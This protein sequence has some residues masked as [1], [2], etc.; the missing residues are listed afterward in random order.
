[1]D[2]NKKY[3]FFS[4]DFDVKS[5]DIHQPFN[6]TSPSMKCSHILF[7]VS[8]FCQFYYY[9]HVSCINK[10]RNIGNYLIQKPKVALKNDSE[11]PK[12]KCE[13]E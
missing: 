11:N 5:Y 2:N 13:S 12:A 8:P 4:T 7:S 3:H 1:M 10:V 6:L 9:I